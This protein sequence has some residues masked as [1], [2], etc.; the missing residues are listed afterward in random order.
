MNGV[1]QTSNQTNFARS[2]VH[3]GPLQFPITNL[4]PG[5]R[6]RIRVVGHQ[7][8]RA[9]IKTKEG[10]SVHIVLTFAGHCEVYHLPERFNRWAKTKS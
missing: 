8:P 2:V 3:T 7:V 5:V 4:E 10:I 1:I 9:F 6:V